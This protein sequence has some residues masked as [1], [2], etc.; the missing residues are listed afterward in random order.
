MN[1]YTEE[2]LRVFQ[3]Q[4]YRLFTISGLLA[5]L[6]NGLSY[7]VT[8]WMVV[9]AKSGLLPVTILMLCS[10][11]PIMLLSPLAGVIADRFSRRNI[12]IFSTAIRGIMIATFIIALRHHEISNLE[13]YL[14]GL[15]QGLM[16]CL[17]GPAATAFVRETVPQKDL[18]SANTTVDM[19]Y[20]VGN[21]VGMGLSGFIIA[22]IHVK[23]ALFFNG[24]MF[25]LAAFLMCFIDKKQLV[26]ENPEMNT[27]R[28]GYFKDF[29]DGLQYIFARKRLLNLYTVQLLIMCCFMTA[30]I[31]LT[32][33]AKN[34][35]HASVKQFGYIEACI[36]LGIIAGGI[37][38]PLL[39]KWYGTF[40]V[41]LIELIM[42]LG[43]FAALT[44][45]SSIDATAIIYLVLGFS[46]S[47]WPLIL[48][49]AQEMTANEFQGRVQSSC[50][51]LTGMVVLIV[52]LMLGM[53]GN[54]INLRFIFVFQCLLCTASALILLSKKQIFETP[55]DAAF[56][57]VLLDPAI[58][59]RD[60][61]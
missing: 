55:T 44:L 15:G 45:T 43:T 17:Y 56:V 18:L 22:L 2:R 9:T 33:F 34:I 25:M 19:A 26:N 47:S 27:E 53:M 3:H 42:M 23:G 57:N 39:A 61:G 54:T 35:L 31:I 6:G 14:L 37:I 48:S 49:S 20:E 7:I 32:P 28:K 1:S 38:T 13:I 30:P 52:Y 10:W 51:S 5:M 40:K 50:Y 59:S 60:D 21:L 11:L 58:K 36:S 24:A 41:V 8:T 29:A 16:G 4:P 12:L 46:L